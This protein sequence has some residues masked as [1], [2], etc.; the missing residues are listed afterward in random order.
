MN[1][2]VQYEEVRHYEYSA[3]TLEE[4]KQKARG[5]YEE[6]SESQPEPTL[7]VDKEELLRKLENGEISEAEY[8]TLALPSTIGKDSIEFVDM[9]EETEEIEIK[10][11]Y[12]K[13]ESY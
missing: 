5:E 4:A 2:M 7:E 1:N 11:E 12:G 6:K 3:D 13:D 10:P 9:E 8:N